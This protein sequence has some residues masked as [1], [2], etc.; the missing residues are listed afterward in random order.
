VPILV[1]CDCGKQMR[2]VDDQAG[3]RVKCPGCGEVLTVPRPAEPEPAPV[4][5]A[6]PGMLDFKCDQCGKAMQ[7]R[8]EHAGKLVKCPGCEAKVRIPKPEEEEIEEVEAVA[9]SKPAKK[10]KDE[11]DVEEVGVAATKPVKKAK[12][13]ALADVEDE[14][15]RPKKR[16]AQEEDEDEDDRPRKKKK[17]DEDED[18]EDRPKKKKKKKKAAAGGMMLWLLIGGGVALVLLLVGGGL[19]TY[20]LFFSG[21][22]ADLDFV[23]DDATNFDSERI[24]D[25]WKNDR[26]RSNLKGSKDDMLDREFGLKPEDIERLTHATIYST[27]LA[28]GHNWTIVLTTSAYD[29]K[30]VKEKVVG[31]DSKEDTVSGKKYYVKKLTDEQTKQYEQNKQFFPN[32]PPPDQPCVYFHSKTIFVKAPNEKTMKK[33]LENYPRKKNDGIMGKAIKKAAGKGYQMVS[34]NS[35][36]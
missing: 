29:E 4:V 34:G 14:D 6:P 5:A 24:A 23:I 12:V 20:F 9:V 2:V 19:G 26:V 1:K 32:T 31:S 10:R 33:V 15:D 11:D 16:K 30:K 3:R 17:A 21:S 28:G 36:K 27:D 18:E 35:G 13:A 22:S 7:A 8:T 25:L